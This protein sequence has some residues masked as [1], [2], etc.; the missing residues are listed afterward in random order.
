MLLLLAIAAAPPF[1]LMMPCGVFELC[2]FGTTTEY[3]FHFLQDLS[4]QNAYFIADSRLLTW[5]RLVVFIYLFITFGRE[6]VRYCLAQIACFQDTNIEAL[7]S[8]LR[9]LPN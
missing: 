5:V 8:P 2:V 9:S 3:A 7:T 6:F 4:R 1:Q